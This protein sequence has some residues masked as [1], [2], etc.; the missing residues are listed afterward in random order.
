[1]VQTIKAINA[2]AIKDPSLTRNMG[3]QSVQAGEVIVTYVIVAGDLEL[4]SRVE[5]DETLPE[6]K[7]K[8]LLLLR[9]TLPSLKFLLRKRT[10]VESDEIEEPAVVPTKTSGIDDELREAFEAVEQEKEKEREKE[11]DEEIPAEDAEVKHSTAVL[12]SE[13]QAEQS[14]SE[15]VEQTELPIAVLGYGVGVAAAVEV[16]RTAGILAV[17]TSPLK[18]P[19]VAMPIHSLPGKAKSKV[20]N[21]AVDRVKI[22]QSTELDLDK[23]QEVVDQLMKDQDLLHRESMAPRAIL[24]ISLGLA[25]DV[26]NLHNRYKDLKPSFK[27]SE[28]CKATHEANLVDY[29]KQKAE[30]DMMVADYKE[31]KTAGDKLEK[32]MEELQKQLANL[33]GKQNRLGAGLSSKTK[34]T[35]LV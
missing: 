10:E 25:R 24:E 16:P 9:P 29:Q 30:L 18:L 23:N 22:W 14:A 32:H 26:L 3:G 5:E 6:G 28:F 2:Q 17:V 35:F 27:A 11:G 1:M 19:I 13:E 7:E 20:M 12:A 21:E 4:P 8:K 33:R 34:S 15:P 31:T